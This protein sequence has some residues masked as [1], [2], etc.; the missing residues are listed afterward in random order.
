MTEAQK[1]KARK[2]GNTPRDGVKVQGGGKP[3]KAGTDTKPTTKWVVKPVVAESGDA[4]KPESVV[5]NAALR[6][7]IAAAVALVLAGTSPNMTSIKCP[8]PKMAPAKKVTPAPKG[9]LGPG[10]VVAKD[11]KLTTKSHSAPKG[12]RLKVVEP[13]QKASTTVCPERKSRQRSD[14]DCPK[15]GQREVHACE[16]CTRA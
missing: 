13:K 6:K 16:G 2:T 8:E 10:R 11:K 5:V 14:E 12:D 7:K 15:P 4:K 1:T 3:P 9:K